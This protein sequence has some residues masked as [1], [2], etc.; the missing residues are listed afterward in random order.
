M[1]EADP[2]TSVREEVAV[3]MTQARELFGRWQELA[4]ELGP[5]S[6][7][8]EFEWTTKELK[9]SLKSIGWDLIDLDETVDVVEQNPAKFN[10]SHSE[11][12]SRRDFTKQTKSECDK[13]SAALEDGRIKQKVSS[14]QRDSLMAGGT[15]AASR[16]AKLQENA[17][18][19]NDTF[20]K[21]QEQ[22]QAMVMRE[23]DNQLQEVH[24]TVG[25]LKVMG[26]A[27]ATELDD[28]AVLLEDFDGEMDSTQA[29]LGRAISKLDKT[30]EI[31][32]DKKQSCCIVLLFLLMIIMIV[33]YISK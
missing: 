17:R 15:G 12:K 21:G 18:A 25:V 4:A 31:S 24:D 29:R 1:A 20:I 33:V 32:K 13:I 26:E 8:E 2:W 11:V 30:L 16:Y 19:E 6:D 7:I 14:A 22:Q 3:S 27:I 9:K 5:T 23:Q 28:Q 10:I